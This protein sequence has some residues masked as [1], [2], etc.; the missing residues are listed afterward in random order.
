MPVTRIKNNVIT[1]NTVAP[2]KLAVTSAMQTF[3][4]NA[5]SANLAS[6]VTDET[7]SGSL[8]FATSPTLTTP[9]IA[10]INGSTS[11]NGSITVQG[12]SNSTRTTSNVDLQPSGGGVTIG[13]TTRNASA[14]FQINST[15]LGFL[16]PVMTSTQRNAISSPASGL[17][18]YSSDL[19]DLSLYNGTAWGEV[20]TTHA[21][22]FTSDTLRNAV[23]DETG[24]GSLV[25]GTAPTLNVPAIRQ[26]N[27]SFSPLTIGGAG[28]WAATVADDV[29][30]VSGLQMGN[31]SNGGGA[32]FRFLIKDNTNHYFAFSQPGANNTLALFGLN[33]SST[34]Y[35]FNTGGTPRDMAIG[36]AD[37]RFLAFATNGAIRIRIAASGGVSIGTTTDAGANNLLVAGTVTASNYN[38]ASG[39]ANFL[40]TPTSANL[41]LAVTDETGSGS[42]VFNTNPTFQGANVTGNLAVTGHF[43][44]AT[45]SFKIPHQSKEGYLQYGV[46]ES[47]EH[48]VYVRGSTSDNVIHLPDHWLWLVDADSVTVTLTPVGKFQPLFVESS[49]NKKVIVGGVEGRYNYVVYGT[50]KDVEPL[51]IEIE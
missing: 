6:A 44:A 26:N 17:V 37:A 33:R 7:G 18:V 14:I 23:S 43:S 10:T 29:D 49:D 28:T 32:D 9:T 41:A 31:V 5:T 36:T 48:S 47:N 38:P 8:V 25:F 4:G 45:K 39:V 46:V 3:L 30:A 27:A 24:S 19:F 20:L 16:P 11:S 34:D 35:I 21:A 40:A 22:S 13:G 15:T 51:Q 50:R 42:L 12:T 2:A 1:D